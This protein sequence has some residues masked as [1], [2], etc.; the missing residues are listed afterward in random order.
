MSGDGGRVTLRDP[1]GNTKEISV[2]D[3]G[4][5]TC[6]ECGAKAP[7]KVDIHRLNRV[8]AGECALCFHVWGIGPMSDWEVE[9]A[10]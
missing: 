5:V 1:E 4:K 8:L 3:G 6:P 7:E 2:K 9:N 10:D